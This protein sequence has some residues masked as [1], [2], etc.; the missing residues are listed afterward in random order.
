MVGTVVEDDRVTVVNDCVG[1]ISDKME[2]I[3]LFIVM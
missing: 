3:C 1:V 2:I